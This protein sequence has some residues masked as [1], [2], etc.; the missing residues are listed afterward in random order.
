MAILGRLYIGDR[1]A[2]FG[3]NPAPICPLRGYNGEDHD[4]LFF[5]CPFSSRVWDAIL[6]KCNVNWTCNSWTDW[7]DVVA[8]DCKGKS[9]A[10]ILKKLGF[11]CT[12]Y[13][14][15]LERN[16]R[17]FN[18]ERKLE[19]VVIKIIISLIRYRCLA[20]KNIKNSPTDAWFQQELRLPATIINLSGG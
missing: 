16:N 20:L 3:I 18:K 17:V 1:L 6:R 14:I 4:H 10:T 7:V 5:H 19:E 15:W 8:R 12:V 9:L 11:C 13:H 2:I